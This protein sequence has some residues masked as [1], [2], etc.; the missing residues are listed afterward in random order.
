VTG[1]DY[2]RKF[3]NLLDG[4]GYGVV[5]IGGSGAGTDRPL[6]DLLFGE[7]APGTEADQNAP[8]CHVA[9]VELKSGRDTTLYADQAEVTALTA[10]CEQFGAAPFLAARYTTQASP[11]TYFLVEPDSAR[12][13]DGGAHGL[14]VEDIRERASMTFQ[15]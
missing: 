4:R 3:A 10:F 7:P 11:T 1:S 14:P 5:R 13:T 8:L 12:R 15:P 2:E 6:P 9:A